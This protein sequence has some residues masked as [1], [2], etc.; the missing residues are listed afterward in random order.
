MIYQGVEKTENSVSIRFIHQESPGRFVGVTI[1]LDEFAAIARGEVE[2]PRIQTSVR[3]EAIP[4][5]L[6]HFHSETELAVMGIRHKFRPA[7]TATTSGNIV[8]LP[9]PETPPDPSPALRRTA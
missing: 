1:S 7:A 9:E 3:E 5:D 6:M 8:Q 4:Q 2:D